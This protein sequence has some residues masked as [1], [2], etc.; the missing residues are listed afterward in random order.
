MLAGGA[1]LYV[2]SSLGLGQLSRGRR[3]RSPCGLRPGRPR[4]CRI[5]NRRELKLDWNVH[6]AF[7]RS[8]RPNAHGTSRGGDNEQ[9]AVLDDICNCLVSLWDQ[10]RTVS[11]GGVRALGWGSTVLNILLLLGALYCLSAVSRQH[12]S[13]IPVAERAAGP[14]MR[15]PGRI[16]CLEWRILRRR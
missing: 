10:L 5:F 2:E 14:A 6:V 13:A 7:D 9:Q 4:A 12:A 1:V 3:R 15:L 11:R 16:L 8:A